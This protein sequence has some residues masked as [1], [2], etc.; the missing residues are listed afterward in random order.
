MHPRALIL[1]EPFS[2]LDKE[3]IIRTQNLIQSAIK[4]LNIPAII[5]THS[6]EHL[7]DMDSKEIVKI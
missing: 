6:L 2:G 7:Q 5:V 3:N 1:D 4:I